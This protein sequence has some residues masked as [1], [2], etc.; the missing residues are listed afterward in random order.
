MQHISHRT[1]PHVS[2]YIY[3]ICFEYESKVWITILNQIP[4]KPLSHW[5][6]PSSFR[7]YANLATHISQ[8]FCHQILCLHFQ[9]SMHRVR[10]DS[11]IDYSSSHPREIPH[12]LVPSH[13]FSPYLEHEWECLEYSILYIHLRYS[14][15][16]HNGG[17]DGEG[18]AR[19]RDNRNRHWKEMSNLCF[20]LQWAN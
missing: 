18:S 4:L 20:V 3:Y 6:L 2:I 10:I 1:E 11:A 14:I 9:L 5:K 8:C 19:L 12:S 17:K 13:L 15:L 16:V 7:L